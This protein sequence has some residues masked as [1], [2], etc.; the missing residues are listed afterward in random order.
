MKATMMKVSDP[1]IFGHVVKVFYKDVF[2]KYGAK[3]KAVGA[4]PNNGIGDIYYKIKSLPEAER[5]E[6]SA[7]IE[8]CYASQPDLAMVDS[9]NGITNLHVPSDVIVDASMPNVIRDEGKMW[10][11]HDK[12]QDTKCL[13]PDRCYAGIY[14]QMVADCKAHGAFDPATMGSVSN[15]GLMA[16][17][18]EEYGSHDKTFEMAAAG[19][20]RVVDSA[21]AV[22][23]EHKVEKGDIWRACQ[24][25][26]VPIQDWVK[27]AVT[28]AKASGEPAIFW[29]NGAR[30][31]DK[32]LIAKVETYLKDHDTS[33]LDISI[34]ASACVCLLKCK[35]LLTCKCAFRSDVCLA[36]FC[37]FFS[38]FPLSLSLSLYRVVFHARVIPS[39]SLTPTISLSH[40]CPLSLS[41]S[42]SLSF[43][44][45]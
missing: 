14:K 5:A 27:L 2:S 26:D 41:L 18:A 6:I 38:F 11:K 17:K 16:Q 3:L 23:M 43:C 32:N 45:F 10:N 15:V 20:M 35:F 25:K 39:R 9:S 22:L 13:I 8:A 33:G 30:A 37:L 34:Q 1:I 7:A 40:V 28:R 36:L 12:L 4:N 24:T 19:T 44:Q 31:H 21:G 42:L 29:L